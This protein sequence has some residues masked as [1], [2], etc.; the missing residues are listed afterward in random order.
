MN[1]KDVLTKIYNK[2]LSEVA[3]TDFTTELP[4]AMVEQIKLLVS[5]SKANKGLIAVLTTLL[6]HKIVDSNQDTCYHQAQQ[7]TDHID[8][9]L[10]LLK[11]VNKLLTCSWPLYSLRN[12][13][14]RNI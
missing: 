7:E 5:R 9:G 10:H 14:S 3:N 2:V 11:Q 13:V 4:D 12:I 1:H 6:T 8:R